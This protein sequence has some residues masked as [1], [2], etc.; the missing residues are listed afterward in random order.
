VLS[1]PNNPLRAGPPLWHVDGKEILGYSCRYLV[2]G[3]LVSDLTDKLTHQ[4]GL[5]GDS[6]H[7]VSFVLGS[8]ARSRLKS[9][10]NAG[11]IWYF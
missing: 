9:T 10:C 7:G 4:V 2:D 5:K 6:I 1:L 3:I 8:H 11:S